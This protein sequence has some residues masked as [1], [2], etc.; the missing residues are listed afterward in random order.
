MPNKTVSSSSSGTRDVRSL[1]LSNEYTAYVDFETDE[2]FGTDEAPQWGADVARS[3]GDTVVEAEGES[4]VRGCDDRGSCALTGAA[5]DNKLRVLLEHT[6]P[7]APL[8]CRSFDGLSQSYANVELAVL[9]F[10]VVH[11]GHDEYA[12]YLLRLDANRQGPQDRQQRTTHNVW[13]RHREFAELVEAIKA[14]RLGRGSPSFF[15]SLRCWDEVLHSKPLFRSL[16]PEYLALK[17]ECLQA[18]VA[19]LLGEVA[20]PDALIQFLGMTQRSSGT[21]GSVECGEGALRCRGSGTGS[22]S[23]NDDDRDCLGGLAGFIPH[24]VDFLCP[25]SNQYTLRFQ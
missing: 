4:G 11:D 7:D 12:Q 19:Q 20:S 15:N 3:W 6:S 25:T 22:G 21:Q 14:G 17:L 8:T 10:R 18:F 5:S 24:I 1:S 16:Q 13:R 2:G 23:N 9:G